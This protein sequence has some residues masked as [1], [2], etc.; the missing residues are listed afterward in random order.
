MRFKEDNQRQTLFN[1]WVKVLPMKTSDIGHRERTQLPAGKFLLALVTALIFTPSPTFA[2]IEFNEL[3]NNYRV[4]QTGCVVGDVS[5]SSVAIAEN[6]QHLQNTLANTQ[7]K[8]GPYSEEYANQA[9]QIGFYFAE[10]GHK[11]QARETLTEALHL[12]RINQGLFTDAQIPILDCLLRLD[13]AEEKW[14]NVHELFVYLEQL[15]RN[16]YT[17]N[18]PRLAYGLARVSEWYVLAHNNNLDGKWFQHLINARNLLES[19]YELARQTAREKDLRNTVLWKNLDYS[20]NVIFS[21][22]MN[23]GH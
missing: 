14:N 21:M 8:H 18:D 15:Y 16:I 13:A 11:H 2:E 10:L 19:R 20:R 7:K 17:P 4:S 22:R 23:S 6:F 5:G 12:N 9:L 1:F 3:T